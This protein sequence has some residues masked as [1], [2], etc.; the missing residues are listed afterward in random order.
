[1]NGRRRGKRDWSRL[2]GKTVAVFGR[3]DDTEEVE[4]VRLIFH[5]GDRVDWAMAKAAREADILVVLTRWVS[6]GVM[7]RLKEY[8]AEREKE[9]YFLRETG[10]Q[11]ILDWIATKG[12]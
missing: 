1:M 6:H 4:G 5:D 2:C 10:T 7:W 11:R 12:D 9:V 3:L 8:A